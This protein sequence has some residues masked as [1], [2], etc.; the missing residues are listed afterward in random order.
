MGLSFGEGE[1]D[2]LYSRA[3]EIVIKQQKVSTKLCTKI[4]TNWL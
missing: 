4:F 2:A 1:I 3:V